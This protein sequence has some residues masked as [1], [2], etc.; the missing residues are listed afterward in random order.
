MGY[1]L[2][3]FIKLLV[4]GKSP[5]WM[6]VSRKIN[7]KWYM[8]H[9]RRVSRKFITLI[10]EEWSCIFL[11]YPINQQQK[12]PTTSQ[13]WMTCCCS[14]PICLV[15][16]P[17]VIRTNNLDGLSRIGRFLRPQW[18]PLG[19]ARDDWGT[20]S[21]NTMRNPLKAVVKLM[22]TKS[23]NNMKQASLDIFG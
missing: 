6:E 5:N 13:K 21:N 11:G 18:L 23:R 22:K 7:H 12:Q 8:F 9:Y 1:T 17:T 3:G 16:H 20:I 2:S 14:S 15:I 19:P 10:A 4:A